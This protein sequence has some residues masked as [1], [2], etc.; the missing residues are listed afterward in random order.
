MAFESYE[1]LMTQFE[2]QARKNEAKIE[3]YNKIIENRELDEEFKKLKYG[4]DKME[5]LSERGQDFEDMVKFVG[6]AQDKGILLEKPDLDGFEF[7]DGTISRDGIRLYPYQIL[8]GD[9]DKSQ[10]E[11]LVKEY[12][13]LHSYLGDSDKDK[14]VIDEKGNLNFPKGFDNF[15]LLKSNFPAI[16][17]TLSETVYEQAASADTLTKKA[18]KIVNNFKKDVEKAVSLK[19]KE[20]KAEVKEMA[21][22]AGDT[23][24]NKM[25]DGVKNGFVTLGNAL[26]EKGKELSALTRNTMINLKGNVQKG[27]LELAEY[28]EGKA[29]A[30]ETFRDLDKWEKDIGKMQYQLLNKGVITRDSEENKAL[31]SMCKDIQD[32]KQ[33][34]VDKGWSKPTFMVVKE[35]VRHAKETWDGVKDKIFGKIKGA[36]KDVRDNLIKPMGKVLD[37]YATSKAPDAMGKIKTGVRAAETKIKDLTGILTEHLMPKVIDANT[38]RSYPASVKPAVDTYMNRDSTVEQLNAVI[39]RAQELGI[40]PRMENTKDTKNITKE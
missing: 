8:A 20:Q 2:E 14:I 10:G 30:K 12:E 35:K 9:F 6:T 22:Y 19:L 38:G 7:K 37:D 28:R 27:F 11:A 33:A 34:I 25:A 1:E 40:N 16:G 3:E 4:A 36:F 24:L 29:A 31:T 18:D 13:A 21:Y 32:A 26:G 23:P 17:L 15:D 5:T 39:A